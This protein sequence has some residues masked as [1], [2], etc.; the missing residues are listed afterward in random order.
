MDSFLPLPQDVILRATMS[1]LKGWRKTVD[2]EMRPQRNRKC[3]N[4]CDYRL[5]TQDVDA[6]RLPSLMV[7]A[8]HLLEEAHQ[9]NFT[10]PELCLIRDM[11]ITD[12]TIQTGTRPGALA[13]ANMQDFQT[14]REVPVA[15]M[16]VMLI[17]DHK[18]GVAG[19]APVT[20]SEDLHKKMKVYLTR[21]M[22][23]FFASVSGNVD[24][25]FVISDGKP[26]VG[27][28]IYSSLRKQL[29]FFAPGPSGISRDGRLQFTA[30]NSILMTQA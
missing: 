13:N 26:F 23:Q 25:L 11:L 19:P 30:E 14:M 22:P 18:R 5:T 4:E 10:M 2:L 8:C 17:L 29:S 1:K 28:T 27:G 3:L 15:K 20:I 7:N 21:I 12:L 24:R 6:L 16:R 9:R